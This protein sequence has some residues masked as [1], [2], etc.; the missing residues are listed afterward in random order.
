MWH[1]TCTQVD[2]QR[3]EKIQIQGSRPIIFN[4]LR[5]LNITGWEGIHLICLLT[6]LSYKY[7]LIA[8]TIN[9]M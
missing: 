1:P 9:Y 6:G 2:R 8:K 7:V 5:E 4:T 3:A